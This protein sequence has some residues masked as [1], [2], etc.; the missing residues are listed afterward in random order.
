MSARVL[1]PLPD[2]QVVM[3]D[4]QGFMSPTWRSFWLNLLLYLGGTSN[5]GNLTASTSY[6]ND[7]AAAAGGVPVGGYYRNGSVVQVR[8]V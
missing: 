6:A 7:A 5:G 2:P 8:V 3:F 4:E 1:P